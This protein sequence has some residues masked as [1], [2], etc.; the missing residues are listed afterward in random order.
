[1]FHGTEISL[2]VY[3]GMREPFNFFQKK[4]QNVQYFEFLCSRKQ[5]PL[6]LDGQ[7]QTKKDKK[8]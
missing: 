5:R 3:R 6:Q 1:M 2:I 4:C 7:N 8:D